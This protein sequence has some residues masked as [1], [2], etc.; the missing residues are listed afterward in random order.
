MIHKWTQKNPDHH[1]STQARASSPPERERLNPSK[2]SSP[3][4]TPTP[5]LPS[6][7]PSQNSDGKTESKSPTFQ[8]ISVA[9]SQIETCKRSQSC[10]S[11]ED[12]RAYEAQLK[13][14][15]VSTLRTLNHKVK[16]GKV[17]NPW[18]FH[19]GM[20][21]LSYE[22]DDVKKESLNLLVSQG[23][24]RRLIDPIF[25]EVFSSPNPES[26]GLAMQTLSQFTEA[27]D[28]NRISQ[29]LSELITHGGLFPALEIVRNLKPLLTPHSRPYFVRAL[30]DIERQEISQRLHA[31]LKEALEI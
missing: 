30:R 24:D 9:L 15:L 18:I 4:K 29:K 5:V 10:Y 7:N 1:A 16:T 22:G 28:Q 3:K 12:P 31:S 17:K 13:A 14:D 19:V 6:K 2:S 21:F 27:S 11:Q 8:E 20:K 26:T 25:E 23:L